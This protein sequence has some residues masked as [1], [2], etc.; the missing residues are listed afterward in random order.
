MRWVALLFWLFLTSL[1][2][3]AQDSA[4]SEA[5]KGFLTGFLEEKLS[6]L[7]RK[8][9]I[10]GFHGALSSRATF[11][12][13]S[14]ADDDG[15]WILFRDGAISWN[16]SALLSG[17][18]EIAELSAAEIQLLRKPESDKPSAEFTGFS[19]PELPVSVSIGQLRADRLVLAAP[20]L[21]QEAVVSIL[22]RADLAGGAGST[23]FSLTRIDGKEGSLT[24]NG[25]YANDT[26]Q[27]TLD[28]LA[29]EG[30][31]GIAAT[32]LNLPG[33]PAAELALHGSGSFADFRTDLA[34]STDKQPRVRGQLLTKA[35]GADAAN[36]GDRT[37]SLALKGDLSPLLSPEFHDFFGTAAT[38][39]A[40]GARRANGQIDLTRM[41]M[42][43]PGVGISGRLSLS[44]E[45]APLAAALTVRLG[46]PDGRDLVLPVSG[47]QTTVKSG[48]LRLRFDGSKTNDWTL[49]GDLAGLTQPDVRIGTFALEGNGR[50]LGS[51]AG[52]ARIVGATSFT[53][54]EIAVRDPALAQA[55][56][57]SLT[58]RTVFSWQQG[59][60][61]RFRQIDARAG[62]MTLAGDV[63]LDV[64][65]LDLAIS[66][67]L[68]VRADSMARFSALVGRP[69]GG[70]AE[71]RLSG[72]G[73]ARAATFDVNV[74]ATGEDL[75]IS[76]PQADRALSGESR[77]SALL[78]RD[79]AG[80]ITLQSAKLDMK[81]LS[82]TAEGMIGAKDTDLVARI[83]TTDL[84]LFDPAFSGA[85]EADLQFAGAAGARS[86]AIKGSARNVMVGA[87]NLD[88]LL[89][90]ETRLDLIARETAGGFIL[91][92]ATV[93]NS[94][95]S[96]GL[97]GSADPGSYQLSG[98][99]HDTARLLPGFGG[100]TR[101][102]GSVTVGSDS[103][104][105]DASVKGPGGI[106]ATARGTVARD[107][108]TADLSLSGSGQVAILN[109]L[110][111]PRSIEGPVGF[112]LAL[113]GPLTLSSLS[114]RVTGSGLRFAS[115]A[116]SLSL[117]GFDLVGDLEGGTLRLSGQAGVRGGGT[118]ELS[119]SVGL[120]A[121][122]EGDLSADLRGVHLTRPGLFQTDLNGTLTFTGSLLGGGTIGGSVVLASTEITLSSAAFG[123]PPLLPVTHVN[124]T[125]E[126][127][128]TRRRAG[129]D[130]KAG[131]SGVAPR[132]GL[133][134]TVS[135][136]ARLF[137]RG[138]GLDAEMGGNVHLRGTTANVEPTGQ[139]KLIRGRL[140]LLGK[141]FNLDEGIVQLIGSMVPYVRFTALADS[142]GTT[143]TILLEGPADK[144]EIHFTSSADVPEEEVL[145]QLLFGRGLNQI[146][147][148]QLAQLANAI[149]TLTG[150]G[151][152][153]VIARLR[154]SVGLDDLDIT[155][156]EDGNA[157]LKAG[158]YL[159]DQL[160]GEASVGVDG[161][162]KIDLN[163][164]LNPD[165]TVHGT[166][167]TDGQTG[168]GILF[169]KD[170]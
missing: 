66:G 80:T 134:L 144:P 163:L 139:F 91:Q 159:S 43:S 40:E 114:G 166:L 46:L 3:A 6:S 105:V 47:G 167:G 160:Y 81:A 101:L 146:S 107:F 147:A 67:A 74:T 30:P 121:P 117:E 111:A 118:A 92:D 63:A 165:L 156:D 162:G 120:A 68:S 133:D 153:G 42:D 44:R 161:K 124:D 4:E 53:A 141:R 28:L 143:A 170:Y 35:P 137:V 135:A 131:R 12:R 96:A 24:F 41:V 113:R 11:T 2:A 152:D 1:P 112:D 126:A 95:F 79:R 71:I 154:K 87:P 97:R 155:A 29:S 88:A 8:V 59:G 26:G 123:P 140:S 5:D 158:K 13:L 39:E 138:L 150:S 52:S 58:G 64:R 103:Y 108:A 136:P 51:S 21:G 62:D 38:L 145:S 7:G 164:D 37:F 18:V 102:D 17:R 55:I 110:I 84:G 23:E 22:G 25:S 50:V 127:R 69:L 76:Q 157:A 119:G 65:G 32:L 60:Q 9:T 36:A 57:R 142:F 98:E 10:D 115:P 15:V 45:Y 128:E 27:A 78:A 168:V 54:K 129:L 130:G 116:E 99:L 151:G 89:R 132:Y 72:A 148:F 20:V 149:A 85:L 33:Q 122:Y 48:V 104:A 93:E 86:L 49:T 61:L 82:A 125:A 106:A 70:A 109:N 73:L 34:I 90:D 14:I 19:L 100:P 56:G 16:R 169:S 75:T 77:I 94:A 31:G 83:A